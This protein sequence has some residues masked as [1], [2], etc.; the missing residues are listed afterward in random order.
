MTNEP[1][2]EFPQAEFAPESFEL[3]DCPR[4]DFQPDYP[5]PEDFETG[6]CPPADSQT[7][8]PPP[9][10]FQTAGGFEP[11]HGLAPEVGETVEVAE[12]Q[13]S[14]CPD[15]QKHD[16][17]FQRQFVSLP[18]AIMPDL[19][20][21]AL[22]YRDVCLY[23]YLLA[24]QGNNSDLWWSVESLA[25]L[26]GI[27]QTGVKESLRK[28]VA[29]GHLRRQR[30]MKSSKTRCVTRVIPDREGGGLLIK[31]QLVHMQKTPQNAEERR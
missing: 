20:N 8:C 31:D 25:W 26:T 16:A 29:S 15:R 19:R 9:E 7:D 28:L 5:P 22:S 14:E 3:V 27:P 30:T 23:C 11:A 1:I 2:P 12:G 13:E 21:R 10:H 4:E 17:I 6:H 18:M 24:K